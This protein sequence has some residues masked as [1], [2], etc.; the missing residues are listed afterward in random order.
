[1]LKFKKPKIKLKKDYIFDFRRIGYMYYDKSNL[2]LV[3][4]KCTNSDHFK[5]YDEFRNHVISLQYEKLPS[6][7]VGDC[8][9]PPLPFP[10]FRYYLIYNPNNFIGE[11]YIS[12]YGKNTHIVFY[13]NYPED[14]D[15]ISHIAQRIVYLGSSANIMLICHNEAALSQK[16]IWEEQIKDY[17]IILLKDSNQFLPYHKKLTTFDCKI[18]KKF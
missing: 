1:M 6:C 2:A 9:F 3:K 12:L 10:I 14:Y 17:N 7:V 5:K 4:V 11:E 16:K 15:K 18:P 13:L 8:K